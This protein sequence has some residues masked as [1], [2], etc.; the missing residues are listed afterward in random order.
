VTENSK[1]KRLVRERMSFTGESYSV[2]R[3]FVVP[4]FDPLKR[5]GV[6]AMGLSDLLLDDVQVALL[7]EAVL[8]PGLVLVV[9]GFE[10]GK[11]SV[12]GALVADRVRAGVKV[13][14][15]EASHQMDLAGLEGFPNLV[16][17]SYSSLFDHDNELRFSA[18]DVV[19]AE[20]LAVDA[21]L[22]FLSEL[23]GADDVGLVS[24][25]WDEKTV[26]TTASTPVPSG[27]RPVEPLRDMFPAVLLDDVVGG[28]LDHVNALVVCYRLD[29][30]V[31]TA[32]DF[33]FKEHRFSVVYPVD[34]KVR[35]LLGSKDAFY[36]LRCRAAVVEYYAELGL[37]VVE[38]VVAP[39]RRFDIRG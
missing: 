12:A 32:G 10:S 8:K 1:L 11:S 27:R 35:G 39:F 22:V 21:E 2:A 28:P 31:R 16:S 17:G 3:K 9:G 34:D 30:F 5:V 26:V 38:D 4:G 15:F 19:L 33:P 6:G 29:S 18:P 13:H 24:G 25:W 7:R 37:P 36:D 23:W 20:E 14:A